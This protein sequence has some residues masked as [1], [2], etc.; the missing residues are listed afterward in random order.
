[1]LFC[2][3]KRFTPPPK[4]KKNRAIPD[5]TVFRL[6]HFIYEITTGISDSAYFPANFI[7]NCS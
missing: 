6:Y 7:R 1:M 2:V 3:L 5:L 4:K